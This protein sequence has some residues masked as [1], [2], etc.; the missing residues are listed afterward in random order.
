MSAPKLDAFTA[1]YIEAALWSSHDNSTESGGYPLD[2]NYSAGDIAP[3]TM[4]RMVSDCA[5]FQKYNANLL[6]HARTPD[7]N[8][9]DFWLTRNR[10]GAGFWDRGLGATGAHLTRAA[11][12]CGEFDLYI[13]DDNQVHGQ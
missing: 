11:Q 2:Q 10:H 6:D 9:H 4:T 8:G 1:A 3:E 12:A 7:Y 5:E 13:G